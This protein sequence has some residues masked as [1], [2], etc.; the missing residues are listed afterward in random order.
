MANKYLTVEDFIQAT[1]AESFYNAMRGFI[2]IEESGLPKYIEF[3]TEEEI[4][5]ILLAGLLSGL[6]AL[7][8]VISEERIKSIETSNSRFIFELR[9]N[10]F[11]VFWIEKTIKNIDTY[12]SIITKIIA[13]FEGARQADI[14]NSLILSNLTETPEYEKIGR[15]LIKIRS[16]EQRYFDAYKRLGIKNNNGIDVEKI[17]KKLSGIDGILVISEEGKILHSEFPRGDPIFQI[18]PFSN[19]IVGL[20]KSIKNLDPGTLEEVTTQNYRFI[21]RD[22]EDFFYV[23]E[24]IK[25]LV[26]KDNLSKTMLKIMSRYE[27]MRR[28]EDNH[29][30]VLKDIDQI[31]EQELLGQL[32]LQ[33]KDRQRD[34]ENVNATLSRE[35]TKITFGDEESKWAKERDQLE[36][37]M[38]IY[39][40]IFML[41][42]ICPNGRFFLSKKT[43]DINDWIDSI[44]KIELDRMLS[45]VRANG[46][47]PIVKLSFEN[48]TIRLAKIKDHS[49]LF[50]IFDADNLAAERYMLR[51]PKIIEKV[52]NN[53]I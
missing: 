50:V 41:G 15:R 28:T 47:K 9:A 6:Q 38:K 33:I 44:S 19:F 49:I 16:G 21:I 26:N 2:V 30:E 8:E 22:G 42:I 40:E 36:N 48:K 43:S 32:S 13:R 52:S 39:K 53:I 45:M 51:M 25:G 18:D 7:A 5:V 11:Y 23:F 34:S 4:D 35:T 17:A 3:L 27:G 12:E 10:Y 24:V 1:L 37:F 31:L 29:F 14:D 46:Y 20:R